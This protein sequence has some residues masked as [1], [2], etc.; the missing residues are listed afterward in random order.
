MGQ[1]YYC[2][3]KVHT[4]REFLQVAVRARQYEERLL[5]DLPNVVPNTVRV[6]KKRHQKYGTMY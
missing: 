4:E 6:K 3:G 5:Y 2:T 1:Q